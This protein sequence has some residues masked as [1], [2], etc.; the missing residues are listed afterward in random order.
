MDFGAKN[1]PPDRNSLLKDNYYL[2]GFKIRDNFKGG[3]SLNLAAIPAQ[4][5]KAS[6]NESSGFTSILAGVWFAS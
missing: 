3:I 1:Q 2:G 5:K 4:E 6:R